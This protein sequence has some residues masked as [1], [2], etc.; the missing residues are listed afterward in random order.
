MV[1]L[2]PMTC[3]PITVNSIML[4][5]AISKLLNQFHPL[6]QHLGNTSCSSFG[7]LSFARSLQPHR[8]SE[9]IGSQAL[10]LSCRCCCFW[11]LLWL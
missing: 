10:L 6:P 9:D 1:E 8:S 5:Q 4:N 3:L 11:P 7:H 2:H